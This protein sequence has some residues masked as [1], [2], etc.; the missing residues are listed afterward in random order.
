MDFQISFTALLWAAS[1]A[2]YVAAM[3][4]R[5]GREMSMNFSARSVAAF[6]CGYP[7]AVV[8]VFVLFSS[9]CLYL[10]LDPGLAKRNIKKMLHGEVALLV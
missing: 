9:I 10:L 4:S 1:F 8:V 6:L 5:K 7:I 2:F 3:A